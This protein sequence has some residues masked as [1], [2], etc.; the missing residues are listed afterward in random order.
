MR[1]MDLWHSQCEICGTC[2][3]GLATQLVCLDGGGDEIF[4]FFVLIPL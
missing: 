3:A 4:V 2:L 1:D